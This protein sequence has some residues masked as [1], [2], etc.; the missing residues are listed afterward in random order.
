MNELASTT[1]EPVLNPAADMYNTGPASDVVS[2]VRYE[3][4]RFLI[5]EGAGATGTATITAE[6][7]TAID[8]TGATAIP[9]RYRTK[10]AD[11]AWGVW[12]AATA[13]GFNTTAGANRMY[14]I[15]VRARALSAGSQFVRLQTV[16]VVDAPVVGGA[17]AQVYGARYVEEP[18][19]RAL[20]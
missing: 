1:A 10:A 20:A 8:G 3:G 4:V 6:E 11:A 7:C 13:T 14:E 17:V 12:T 2:L 9:F 18:P 16:E 19:V 15:E 5:H